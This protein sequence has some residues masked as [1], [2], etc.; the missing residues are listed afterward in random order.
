MVAAEFPSD[1]HF[2][3]LG[4]SFCRVHSRLMEQGLLMEADARLPSVTQVDPE[5]ATGPGNLALDGLSASRREPGKVKAGRSAALPD[6]ISDTS[7][8]ADQ[9]RRIDAP[10]GRRE[11]PQIAGGALQQ[12]QR[13]AVVSALS[14]AAADGDLSDAL[15]K[16]AVPIIDVVGL[17]DILE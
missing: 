16:A 4:R 1:T 13:A 14:V 12:R 9:C 10:V 11:S 3:D 17:T 6:L 7:S 5:G 15:P 2:R 8:H